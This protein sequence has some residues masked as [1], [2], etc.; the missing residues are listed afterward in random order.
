MWVPEATG[1]GMDLIVW[2]VAGLIT[3]VGVLIA[4]HGSNGISMVGVKL[5]DRSANRRKAEDQRELVEA[6]AA[7]TENLR[8]TISA[9]SGLEQAIIA[10]ENHSPRAISPAVRRLVASL[11]YGT[12]ED[13]LRRFADDV[14]HPTCDF[15]VAA[16]IT[17]AQ[18]QTR[19]VG[20]LLG[21][22]SD[23]ARSEC[24]LYLRI[25]VSRARSRTAV[26][27]ITG[28]VGTF[29]TGLIVFNRNYLAPFLSIEGTV[30]LICIGASFATALVWLQRIAQ[31]ST[32]ARFLSGREGSAPS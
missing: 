28:A 24:H 13:G 5:K 23:C 31:I 12:L 29:V 20:Q 4:L 15:V 9:S 10:T 7:W 6:V 2:T 14:S 26:R 8:D 25:W 11:R 18:H 16:L 22:L 21:H 27:I 17:S 19:D 32:P 1:V 3:A 30:V